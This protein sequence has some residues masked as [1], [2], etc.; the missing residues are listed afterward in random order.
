M[1]DFEDEMSDLEFEDDGPLMEGS[2]DELEDL[3]SE[4]REKEM[5][6]ENEY[7]AGM[8]DDEVEV[9]G[10]HNTGEGE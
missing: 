3:Q 7:G 8:P 10:E 4:E 9:L 2:G 5:Y 6:G 1:P